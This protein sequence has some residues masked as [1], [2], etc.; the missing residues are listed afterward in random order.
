MSWITGGLKNSL[1]NLKDQASKAINDALQELGKLW[2]LIE[3][4]SKNDIFSF[5]QMKKRQILIFW[6]K[7]LVETQEQDFW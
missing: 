5:W 7:N 4:L 2:H 1:S 3:L 6:K